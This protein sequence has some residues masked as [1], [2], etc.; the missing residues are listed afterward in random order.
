[1]QKQ[2]GYIEWTD[3]V[4]IPAALVLSYVLAQ[5]LPSALATTLS[6]VLVSVGLL[7]LGNRKC[8]LKESTIA[9]LL[10]AIITFTLVF[11]LDWPP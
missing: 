6:V 9:V 5:W 7:L 11:F 4:F 10:G 8:D 3:I 1:M 2:N